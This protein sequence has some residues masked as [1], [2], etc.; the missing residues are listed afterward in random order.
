MT[1]LIEK[2]Q[3]AIA[4]RRAYNRALNEIAKI[5]ARELADL[6]TDRSALIANAYREV[7]GAAQ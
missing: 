5:D 6:H 7:Y 2:L 1:N 3:T 4:H